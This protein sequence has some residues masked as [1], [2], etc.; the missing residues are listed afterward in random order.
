[1]ATLPLPTS[2]MKSGSAPRAEVDLSWVVVAIAVGICPPISPLEG[3]VRVEGEHVVPV[4]PISESSPP[5]LESGLAVTCDVVGEVEARR[6]RALSR[7]LDMVAAIRREK[8]TGL[9]A[10][11]RNVPVVTG[12]AEPEIEREPT[13]DRPLVRRVHRRRVNGG[14][15]IVRRVVG[16]NLQSGFRC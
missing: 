1:M 10:L 4:A 11:R 15:R 2:S 7:P 6:Q 9:P 13:T 8:G 16:Q 12:P 3:D 14:S 5:A